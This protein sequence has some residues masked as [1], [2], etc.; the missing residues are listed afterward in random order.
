M[1]RD[2]HREE[3]RESSVDNENLFLIHR[4]EANMST[5]EEFLSPEECIVVGEEEEGEVVCEIQSGEEE[6][7]EI[8]CPGKDDSV[9]KDILGMDDDDVCSEKSFDAGHSKAESSEEYAVENGRDTQKK[10]RRRFLLMNF[11]I[12]DGGI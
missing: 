8:Y 12:F 5:E 9:L 3:K 4:F 1:N 11:F 2:Y 10:S 7:G 6:A